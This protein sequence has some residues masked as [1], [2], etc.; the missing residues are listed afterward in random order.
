MLRR[1]AGGPIGADAAD[2][3]RQVSQ[4]FVLFREGFC[5]LSLRFV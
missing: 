3:F 5:Q 4:R 2:A 1:R